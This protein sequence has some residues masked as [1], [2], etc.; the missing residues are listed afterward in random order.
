MLVED[1]NPGAAD[2]DVGDED[3]MALGDTL[4]F[5]ADD[6]MHGGELWALPLV[7]KTYLPLVL[8]GG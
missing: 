2:G 1:I 5:Y 6:G 8:Q 4:Y 3:V 7:L